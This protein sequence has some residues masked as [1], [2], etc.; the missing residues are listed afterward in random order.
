MRT[1]LE[2]ILKKLLVPIFTFL[3]FLGFSQSGKVVT[4]TITSTNGEP[5][6]GASVIQKG[7][8]NGVQSDFDGNYQIQLVAGADVLVFSYVGFSPREETV[9]SRNAIDVVLQEDAQNLDEVVVIG[10]GS[11]RKSDITGAVASVAS[12]DLEK[13]VFNTVDQLLQGRS[14]GVL[15]TSASGEPGAPANI[16]IRGNNS[17][18]GDNSPLY[19]VDGIPISGAPNFNPQEIESLEVLKDASATAI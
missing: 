8:Q 7:T 16:R 5:L 4:G 12:E 9:G 17:I 19:V 3:C 18:S 13:A 10:Y 1:I 11:Q 2:R 15:V 6:P 14:S